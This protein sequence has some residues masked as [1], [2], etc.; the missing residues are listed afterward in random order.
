MENETIVI[1]E[2]AG[3]QTPADDSGNV[4]EDTTCTIV[5]SIDYT[6]QLN[7][8]YDGIYTL[9]VFV[10]V[11][12]SLYVFNFFLHKFIIKRSDK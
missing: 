7:D 11:Y 6:E 12:V 8:I 1:E 4:I 2:L 5:E 9:N 10:A 3:V